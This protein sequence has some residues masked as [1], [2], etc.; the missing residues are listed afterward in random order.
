MHID[1][2]VC[3]WIVLYVYLIQYGTLNLQKLNDQQN[4]MCYITKTLILP[5]SIQLIEQW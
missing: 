3:I 5:S 2:T 1:Y 4:D